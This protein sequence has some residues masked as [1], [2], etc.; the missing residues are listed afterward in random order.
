MHGV[1]SLPDAT[2][3]DKLKKNIGKLFLIF[4]YTECWLAVILNRL[5]FLKTFY[6][7]FI[8]FTLPAM[9]SA[10]DLCQNCAKFRYTVVQSRNDHDFINL[11]LP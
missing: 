9:I 1:I 7:N 6:L 11:K 4:Y 3:Y 8:I 2:S 5:E 10:F